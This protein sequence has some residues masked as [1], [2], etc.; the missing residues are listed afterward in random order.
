MNDN[1]Q[2]GNV[3]EQDQQVEPSRGPNQHS[4]YTSDKQEHKSEHKSRDK[5]ERPFGGERSEDAPARI[6]SEVNDLPQRRAQPPEDFSGIE[7]EPIRE[8][9]GGIPAILSTAKYAWR[10]MGALR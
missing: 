5:A 8:V 6:Q 1:I 10:E 4:H 2:T 9:A 3:A 7:V